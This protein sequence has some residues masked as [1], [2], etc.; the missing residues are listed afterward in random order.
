MAFTLTLAGTYF[1]ARET[2]VGPSLYNLASVC[3][4]AAFVAGPILHRC[5]AIQ[6]WLFAGALGLTAIADGIWEAYVLTT[7]AAPYP[8][9]GDVL[10][11]A[12]YPLFFIGAL[13]LIRGSR[14]RKGDVLDGLM[15]GTVAAFLIWILLVAP[16][17]NAAGSPLLARAVS[18]AYPTMDVLLVIGL[19]TLFITSRARSLSHLMLLLGFFVMAAADLVYAVFTLQGQYAAG[20]W[21]DYGWIASYGILGVAALHPSLA[22][23]G[24]LIPER[25]GALGKGRLAIIGAALAVGPLMAVGYE[26][27]DRNG[28]DL[29]IPVVSI[30]AI[31]LVLLRVSLLW[32]DRQGA[33]RRCERANRA[34]GRCTAWRRAPASG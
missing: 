23:F 34:T 2:S 4:C 14:P 33:E 20:D 18:A 17:A 29:A 8:S 1:F 22:R 27:T 13:V 3:A 19:A 32:R 31:T 28:L 11:L 25:R 30:V 26:M 21:I 7:G 10:Y 6:W 9:I 16:I 5:R 15:L 24:Q 12:A